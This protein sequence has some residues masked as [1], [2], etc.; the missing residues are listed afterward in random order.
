MI[1]KNGEKSADS[2][3]KSEC[4]S[5]KPSRDETKFTSSVIPRRMQALDQKIKEAIL[6][7]GVL[8]PFQSVPYAL[9]KELHFTDD[10][11]SAKQIR[12]R[13]KNYVN[14]WIKCSF[15]LEEDRELIK[16]LIEKNGCKWSTISKLTYQIFNEKKYYPD[17]ALKNFYHSKEMKKNLS[18][19]LNDRLSPLIPISKSDA[20][21]QTSPLLS[22][23]IVKPKAVLPHNYSWPILS[24]QET[25]RLL[26]SIEDPERD[27]INPFDF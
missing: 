11:R 21:C 22:P 20:K 10:S 2:P 13:W 12:E 19:S 1:I 4:L 15:V 5:I 14:P 3:F 26:F 25:Q 23:H 18:T 8:S 7:T 17:N 6:A 27:F 16:A 9:I 24:D